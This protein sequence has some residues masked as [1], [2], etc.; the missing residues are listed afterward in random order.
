[1]SWSRDVPLPVRDGVWKGWAGKWGE[2]GGGHRTCWIRFLMNFLIFSNK[3][4]YLLN[5]PY[6]NLDSCKLS[7]I[8]VYALQNLS[9]HPMMMIDILLTESHDFWRNFYFGNCFQVHR[10]NDQY[11]KMEE[12]WY[13]QCLR[14]IN[15]LTLSSSSQ[16]WKHGGPSKTILN[17]FATCIFLTF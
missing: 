13:F 10:V 8:K 5:R 16:R 1:M 3:L 11:T 7:M 4:Y 15:L 2:W 17:I 6:P 14:T 9:K 12:V